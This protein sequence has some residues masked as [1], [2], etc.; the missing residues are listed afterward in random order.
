MKLK[1]ILISLVLSPALFSQ[2]PAAGYWPFNGNANDESGNGNNGTVFSASLTYDR[3]GNPNSAFHFNGAGNYISVPDNPSIELTSVFTV[4]FWLKIPDYSL[5]VD[6]ERVAIGKQRVSNGTGFNFTAVSGSSQSTYLAAFND[7]ANHP[8]P[9]SDS[10]ELDQWTFISIVSN[11][12]S[13]KLYKDAQL[14]NDVAEALNL[15]NST[16]PFYFGKELNSVPR[17][18]KGDLDDIRIFQGALSPEQVDSVYHVDGWPCMVANYPFSGNADDYSD[19]GLNAIVNGATLT[20]DRFGNPNS[21]YSF[22]GVND[23]IEILDNP[24]MELGNNFTISAWVLSDAVP[25][26]FVNGIITKEQSDNQTG[27]AFCLTDQ[28]KASMGIF[29]AGLNHSLGSNSG[30]GLGVWK[31]VVITYNGT[32]ARIYIDGQ[33]DATGTFT[34]SIF[35]SNNSWFIGKEFTYASGWTN[36]FWKGKIDDVRFYNCVLSETDINELYHQNGWPIYPASCKLAEYNFSGHAIDISGNGNNGTIHGATLTQ[37]RFGNPSSAYSFDGVNDYIEILDNE[38]MELGNNFSISAWF[39]SKAI[40]SLY[41]SS[42]LSK[43]KSSNQSGIGINFSDTQKAGFM[44]LTFAGNH[45]F[46]GT[47]SLGLDIWRNVVITYDGSLAKLYVDG[48]LEAENTFIDAVVNSA[49]SWFIGKEFTPLGGGGWTNRYWN[50]KIDDIQFYSCVL[51]TAEID[52]IFHQNGW[53]AVDPILVTV[54][55]VNATCGLNNGLAT[56]IVTGGYPPYEYIWSNGDTLSTSG[57]LASGIYSLQVI[58]ANGNSDQVYVNISNADGATLSLGSTGNI[59]CNGG[60]DG[61]INLSITGGELPYAIEWSN[62][63]T[64]QDISNLSA[65]AYEVTVT[66]VNGCVSTLNQ[67]LT[68]PSPISIIVSTTDATCSGSDG[69]A[70]AYAVGGT[71]TYSYLWSNG[72]TLTDITNLPAGTYSLTVTDS[73]GCTKKNT[74]V[75]IHNAGGPEIILD[76][77]ADAGCGGN[78]GSIWISVSGGT[79]PYGYSWSNSVNTE[80]N[81]NIGSGEYFLSVTDN[82]GCIGTFSYELSAPSPLY[83]PICMVSVDS[84]SNRNIIIW[85]KVQTSGLDHYNVYREGSV[86]DFFYKIGEVPADSMS[87]FI[88]PAANPMTRAW[89]YKISAVDECG[90]E[91]ELSAPHKTLHLTINEGLGQTVNLVWDSYEGFDYYTFNIWR[92]SFGTGWEIIDSLP[93]N[94]WTYTDIPPSWGELWYR[95]SVV[96]PDTCYPSSLLKMQGGPYS[97]SYSNLDDNSTWVGSTE[98]SQ[99]GRFITYPNPTTGWVNI[100]LGEGNTGLYV[101][102]VCNLQGQ[103]LVRKEYQIKDSSEKIDLDL[104]GKASGLYFVRV[105]CDKY[106]E[107]A[108]IILK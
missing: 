94:M 17:Y 62:G 78:D 79:P 8:V 73:N 57:N 13:V 40:P 107:V 16:E 45:G 101:I 54:D 31:N 4:C 81:E 39:L 22:D 20:E 71:G 96:T 41:V 6:N 82:N 97:H 91:S 44:F 69:T 65:G 10:L 34:N 84:T 70:S 87:E 104:S 1:L 3:F 95:V 108:K 50:G 92:Y 86:M 5:G 29:A 33:L 98:V 56:A 26:L 59:S 68:Q 100:Q 75:Y 63:S 77:I 23:Y 55:V 51:D 18:F 38:Q 61:F 89:R 30:I 80:D 28:L 36:R 12:S 14:I 53:T 88:D 2:I 43:E 74:G 7:G 48:Q 47:T 21:A 24:Q 32:E 52:S 37:D 42:V 103:S 102:E 11:G 27:F 85:E 67:V 72:S 35:N 15:I 76:S 105:Q 99:G 93:A 46:S 9:S 83:Q 25:S 106:N 19:N 66:D 60:S 64:E 49:N 58:D 90:E